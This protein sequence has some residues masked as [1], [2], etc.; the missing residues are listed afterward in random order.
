MSFLSFF[1]GND[2]AVDPEKFFNA[3]FAKKNVFHEQYLK[4]IRVIR[5]SPAGFGP[6]SISSPLFFWERGKIV[7]VVGKT[8]IFYY[9]CGIFEEIKN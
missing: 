8:E 4:I 3:H 5:I 6:T 9:L 7:V 1:F 2:I